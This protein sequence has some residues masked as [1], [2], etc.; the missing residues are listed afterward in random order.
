MGLWRILGLDI[1]RCNMISN[2]IISLIRTIVPV[3]VGAV[4]SWL[5]TKYA[6]HVNTSVEG[7]VTA[8]M[9]AVVTS[10]YYASIRFL[11][12]KFPKGP[13]GMFLGHTARPVYISGKSIPMGIG[14]TGVKP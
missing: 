11:E 8:L 6:F 13:W 2:Y 12:T 5:L 3:A 14:E 1:V 10:G 9:T 7:S 4:A